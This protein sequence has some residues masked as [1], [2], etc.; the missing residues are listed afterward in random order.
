M[1]A[2]DALSPAS[3]DLIFA[4]LDYAVENAGISDAGFTPF[5]MFDSPSGR[6]LTRFV[7][8][9]GGNLAESLAAGREELRAVESDVTCVALAWDGY[10]TH[11]GRRSEAV[12]VEAYEIGQD[13][14]LLLT[15]PYTRE[16]GGLSPQ[17]NPRLIGE[18]E[19]VVAYRRAGD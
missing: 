6:S 5:A 7:Y 8:G 10:Y 15:Q 14:G 2:W 1:T 18:P 9:D 4:A 16:G 17:G 11:E 3:V 19:P 12:F 13:K